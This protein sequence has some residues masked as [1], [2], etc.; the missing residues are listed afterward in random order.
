MRKAMFGC[1][2]TK[3]SETFMYNICNKAVIY[4]N[5]LQPYVSFSFL[6]SS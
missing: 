2:K 6:L 1:K 4:K 5:R 3:K